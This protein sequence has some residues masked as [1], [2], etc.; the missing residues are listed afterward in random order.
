MKRLYRCL[1]AAATLL[2]CLL[3]GCNPEEKTEPVI[4]DNKPS[5]LTASP[6]S[7]TA[8]A[9]GGSFDLTLKGPARPKLSGVPDWISV[10]DGTYQ[11]YTLPLVLTVAANPSYD[12]RNAT[13]TISCDGA[14]SLSYTVTQ[15]GKERPV[16]PKP[17]TNDAWK[18]A[19]KLALGWNMGNQ[20]DAFI[21]WDSDRKDFPDETV[22]GNPKAT[23]ATFDGVKKAGFTSVRIPITWLRMIGDAPQY[24]IDETWMN[25][26]AEV[27]GF[28]EKAGLNVIIN[29]HHDECNND[30]HWLDVLGASKDSSKDAAI[31]AEITAVWTQIAERF[32]DKGDFL[33]FESFNEIQDGGWGWSDEFRADPAKQCNVLNGWN[34]TFVD[35]VR[36]TGGNNATRWLGV[37]TYAA[38]PSFESYFRMPSD[39]AGHLMLAVHFYDPS[40]YTIGT[41]QY[42]DW[43]H[44]GAAGKKA[45]WG[46]EDHVKET[47]SNLNTK[48][49]AKNIPV[50]L[51]EFGCSMRKKSDTRAWG[52]YLYYME[53]VVKA[54]KIYGLPAFLWDNGTDGTGQEQHGY[55]NHGTGNYIGN[56]KEV[57]D[58]MVKAM[59]TEKADY[60]L[61]DVYDNAPKP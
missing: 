60:T 38:N 18:M 32:K 33:I 16:D 56:S 57:I 49:V 1:L 5:S 6:A 24:K 45:S 7:Y 35:A 34:Q 39:P 59:F 53:Y 43:G 29:T 50:Y 58:L 2:G 51:G 3:A 46:D 19:S 52:F 9:A 11:D 20:L 37:P 47:F 10:K 44:T 54:A 8:E 21:N 41:Q 22:W 23:Q 30:G 13:L 17:G 31:K 61:Q 55:I 27:V 26:V 48:Y 12:D 36:A 4:P 15:K 25:R 40:E 28:A 42:S 14:S